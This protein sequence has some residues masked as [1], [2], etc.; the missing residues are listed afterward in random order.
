M[1][2][3]TA[4]KKYCTILVLAGVNVKREVYSCKGGNSTR[5]DSLD[6]RGSSLKEKKAIE[7]YL[8]WKVNRKA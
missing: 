6:S 5:N 1:L 8:C 7:E 2:L 3:T 4:Q